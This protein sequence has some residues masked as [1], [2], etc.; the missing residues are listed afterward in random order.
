[1]ASEGDLFMASF[2]QGQGRLRVYLCPGVSQRHRFSGPNGLAEFRAS[3]NFA[4]SPFGEELRAAQPAGP[5]ATYPGDDSWTDEPFTEGVV[6]IGDAAGYNNPIIGQGLSIAIR[7]A[8][9]VLYVLRG[10][11]W[12]PLA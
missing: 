11:V 2:H 6:L 1:L 12:S 8:R 3:A 9:A 10:D 5:L 7:D 4:C